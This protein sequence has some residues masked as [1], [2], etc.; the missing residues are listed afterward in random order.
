MAASWNA[1]TTADEVA[2]YLSSEIKNKNVLITGASLGSLGGEAARVVAKYGNLVILA[3][4]NQ[5]K[6]DQTVAS[7]KAESPDANL[8]TVVLDLTSFASVKA[9]AATVNTWTEPIHV[10]I[11]NAAVTPLKDLTLTDDVESQFYGNFLAHFLFT[12]LILGRIKAAA[13][14]DFSP[15]VVIVSSAA[16]AISPVR[17]EDY[18][19]KDGSY[20]KFVAYAQS[21]TADIL[22]SVEL[23]KR[24][25]KDGILSFSLH[26]GSIWTAGSLT[27]KEDLIQIG[28]LDKDGNVQAGAEE[29]KSLPAGAATHI[30][31]AFDPSITGQSGAYLADC[32][33]RNEIVA[34]H[35]VD[36]ESAVK[37]WAL[38]EKLVGQTF[39]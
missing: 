16:H 4:R 31:A 25:A 1:K 15:R 17:F 8:R 6:L 27:L 10:L 12:N 3:G 30:V 36:P 2:K 20:N 21:K 11:N 33:V 35:A 23:T 37:L 22:F 5:E 18:N 34:P 32:K 24:Y 38:A 13:S 29:F 14:A 39:A 9:A 19:F 7:I 26:P 28:V